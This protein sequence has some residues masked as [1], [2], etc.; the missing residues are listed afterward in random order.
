MYHA[1]QNVS[2]ALPLLLADMLAAPL[3]A[4]VV[5]AKEPSRLMGIAFGMTVA[6]GAILLAARRPIEQVL[7]GAWT[8]QQEAFT[9]FMDALEGRLEVVA[10]GRRDAF[11]AQLRA[12]A[13]AWGRAGARVAAGALVSGKLPFL[14]I[15]AIALVATA[16]ASTHG[17]I[18]LGVTTADIALLASMTPA[19]TGIAQDLFSLARTKRWMGVVARAV[20]EPPLSV[21]GTHAPPQLPG[22][23][24]FDRVSF[25]YEGARTQALRDVSFTWNRERVL[26]L[27]GPNGS[28]KSTCLRL[29]LALAKPQSGVI[30]VGGVR[31]ERL[32]ADAWRQRIAFLP[33]RPYLPPR[34]DV[35][36]AIRFLAPDAADN[37]M[38][39]ALDRVGLSAALNRFGGDPLGV[40]IGVLSMGERQR[41]GVARLLCQGA[42][43]I[44][45]DEPDANLDRDG[46]A[47]MAKLVHE[48]AQDA[49]IALVAHNAE[50]LDVA[51]RVLVLD[52]GCLV[53]DET[54][55][56][57]SL[58]S[59]A[60]ASRAGRG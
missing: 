48:L 56:R 23:I 24:A 4:I 40:H 7:A 9:A 44:L 22:A 21:G 13:A 10:S 17:H 45:L 37:S 1:A 29:L 14:F 47:L 2:V 41:I 11:V 59:L 32:D 6:A 46:V 15:A 42:S 34:S 36:A 31:L 55:R 27:T 58:P 26:A 19:F 5:I 51:D 25:F 54:N 39:E 3:L 16:L 53:R 8:A 35:G 43:L 12:R 28:G 20:S 33:Q 52:G 18:A 50:L 60:G 30:T 38:R 49:M 57:S